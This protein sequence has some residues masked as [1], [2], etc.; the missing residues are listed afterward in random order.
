MVDSLV[1]MVLYYFT[2]YACGIKLVNNK[3]LGVILSLLDINKIMHMFSEYLV[4]PEVTAHY[5]N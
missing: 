3:H 4:E 5:I 2:V 1:D